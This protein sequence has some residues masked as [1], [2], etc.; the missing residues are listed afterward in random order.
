MSTQ[1]DI[2]ELRA[3]AVDARAAA[4]LMTST[5]TKIGMMKI[6]EEY[7]RLLQWVE[8]RQKAITEN[9]ILSS[10]EYPERP[11]PPPLGDRN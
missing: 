3:R 6:A 4:Y 1:S 2:E 11:D 8:R 7:D 10:V 5:E 9:S